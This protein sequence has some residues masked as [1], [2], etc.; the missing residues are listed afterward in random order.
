MMLSLSA[1]SLM[2]FKT[3]VSD[4]TAL[5]DVKYGY[6]VKYFMATHRKHTESSFLT[7]ATRLVGS[8]KEVTR[9]THRQGC[10]NY[11][12]SNVRLDETPD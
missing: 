12:I 6:M 10:I 7:A 11:M 5:L 3:P 9:I 8:H 2:L 1:F 4:F